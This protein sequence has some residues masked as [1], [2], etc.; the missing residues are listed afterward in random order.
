MD[1]EFPQTLKLLLEEVKQSSKMLRSNTILLN[2]VNL[3][4]NTLKDRKYLTNKQIEN[5]IKALQKAGE[6]SVR[7]AVY[8]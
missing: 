1:S 4:I 5:R 7:M 3:A 6:K 2:A 8:G